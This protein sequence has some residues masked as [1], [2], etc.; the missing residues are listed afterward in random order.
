[1]YFLPTII[2]GLGYSAAHAQ[3]LTIPPYVAGCLVTVAFGMLSDRW[4]MRGPFVLIGA[5]LGLIGYVIL[6]ATREAVVGYVGTIIASCG[7][8]PAAACVLA[9][10]GGNVG[11]DVKRGVVIAMT[12]GLGNLGGRVFS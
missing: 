7:L 4:T 2:T 1:M 3:L 10:T 11:G 9:W 6:Y 8:F 5:L 12:I